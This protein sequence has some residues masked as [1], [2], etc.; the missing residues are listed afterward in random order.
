LILVHAL[1]GRSLPFAAAWTEHSAGKTAAYQTMFRK[2]G[3]APSNGVD[4]PHAALDRKDVKWSYSIPKKTLAHMLDLAQIKNIDLFVDKGSSKVYGLR[5]QDG[6]ES[7]DFDFFDLQARLG[8][9]RLQSSDFTV[10]IKDDQVLFS[11]FGK[12]HGVGLCLYSASAMAQNGDNAVKILAKFFP[13]TYLMN[14]NALP[15]SKSRTR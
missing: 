14:L 1:D 5:V 13:E 12:G 10:T 4:A 9:Q 7:H 11:G 2:E 8:E 15:N 3:L 6:V